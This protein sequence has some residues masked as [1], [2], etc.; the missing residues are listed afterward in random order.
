MNPY[1][2]Y[3]AGTPKDSWETYWWMILPYFTC[4]H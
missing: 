3:P 2:D 1:L 4:P